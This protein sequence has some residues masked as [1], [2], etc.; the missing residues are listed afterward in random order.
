MVKIKEI[1]DQ[2]DE[3]LDFRINEIDKELFKLIN[4]LRTAHKLEKPHMLKVLKK[5]KAQIL[6]VLNERKKNR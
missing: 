4:E 2:S 3:Q 1:K 6:T 5:E